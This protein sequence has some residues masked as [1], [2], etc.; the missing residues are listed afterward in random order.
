LAR[1]LPNPLEKPVHASTA[2]VRLTMS[3]ETRKTLATAVCLLFLSE[4]GLGAT[5]KFDKA[6]YMPPKTAGSQNTKAGSPVKGDVCFDKETKTL[7]FTDG[8]GN[9]VV[10]IPYDKIKSMLYEQTSRPRY[11]EAILLSPFFLFSKTKK[12]FLTIQYTNAAGDGQF[13]MIHMD[14]SNARDIVA[15]AQAESGVKVEWAQEK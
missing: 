9:A 8:K 5:A 1:I 6:E 15:E 3:K 10:S 7:S 14:K 13:A 2:E 4:I 12:H 11:A